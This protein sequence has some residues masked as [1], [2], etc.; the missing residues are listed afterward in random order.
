MAD[1]VEGAK[2]IQ[3]ILDD[4]QYRVLRFALLIESSKVDRNLTIREFTEQALMKAC[5]DVLGASE[6]TQ[7]TQ[8]INAYQGEKQDD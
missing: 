7:A 1:K 2:H 6:I 4:D 5:F 3:V 8:L